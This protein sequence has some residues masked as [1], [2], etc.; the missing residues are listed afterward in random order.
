M[1]TEENKGEEEG[2]DVVAEEGTEEDGET[3]EDS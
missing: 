3:E 1:T 2:D